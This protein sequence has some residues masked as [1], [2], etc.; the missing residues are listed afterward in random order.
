MNRQEI[1]T[2]AIDKAIAGGWIPFKVITSIPGNPTEKL[3]SLAPQ[4]YIFNHDFAKTLWG[5]TTIELYFPDSELNHQF[6]GGI[7]SYPYDEGSSMEFNCPKWKYHIQMMV[8]ADDPI[9]YLRENL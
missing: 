5:D 4:N 2:K 6:M 3:V 1:L 7:L 8:I 9:A